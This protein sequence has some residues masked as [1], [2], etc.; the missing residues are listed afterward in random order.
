MGSKNRKNFKK[1]KM[2][3]VSS[4]TSFNRGFRS[5]HIFWNTQVLHVFLTPYFVFLFIM[6]L[7]LLIYFSFDK[8][9]ICNWFVGESPIA[10]YK[11]EIVLIFPLLL[12][13]YGTLTSLSH[14][15]VAPFML[16]WPDYLIFN[17]F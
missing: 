5:I 6:L 10:E 13:S 3:T 2:V 15:A 4:S 12:P 14:Q 16:F 9:S 17:N 1:A 7:S 11:H 8:S